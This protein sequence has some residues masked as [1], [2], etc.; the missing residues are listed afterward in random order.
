MAMSC[1]ENKQDA[2]MNTPEEV[3]KAKEQTPDVADASFVDGMT[4]KAWNNYLQVRTALVESDAGTVQTVA[5]NLAESFG[6]QRAELKSLA[7]QMADSDD[8][9][10]QRELFSQFGQQ[11][12][13]LFKNGL[14]EG[15]IYKQY[16][17]MA[18]NNTG[19]YWF[20]DVDEIRNPY[21]GD[22]MLKC[23]SVTETIEK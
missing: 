4:G 13:N 20:S 21:F 8:I 1:K 22:R 14:S 19:G 17:P 12:E 16:C 18:F 9:E 10:K 6:E 5:G 7:Q 3:Q 2:Q 15:T 23:G 11:A